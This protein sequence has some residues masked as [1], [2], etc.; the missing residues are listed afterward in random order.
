MVVLF[1]HPETY[2]I[3]AARR[4]E[5][6]LQIDVDLIKGTDGKILSNLF[7]VGVLGDERILS[8]RCFVPLKAPHD[9][10]AL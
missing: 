3:H 9:S 8:A 4:Y 7:Q 10:S 1:M 2:N 6:S 5:T